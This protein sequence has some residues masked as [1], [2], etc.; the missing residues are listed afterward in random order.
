LAAREEFVPGIAGGRNRLGSKVV[1][2]ESFGG[3]E[4]AIGAGWR[5]AADPSNKGSRK[6]MMRLILR[7]LK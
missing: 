4:W 6:G 5:I 7:R 1:D 2:G 3:M